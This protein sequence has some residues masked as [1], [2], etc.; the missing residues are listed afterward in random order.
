[1]KILKI[2]DKRLLLDCVQ[3]MNTEDGNKVGI[4]GGGTIAARIF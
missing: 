2:V 1:M 4:S 3:Q